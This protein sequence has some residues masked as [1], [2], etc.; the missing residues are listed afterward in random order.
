MWNSM[1]IIMAQG[2]FLVGLVVNFSAHPN[3]AFMHVW[4]Y[5]DINQE[6]IYLAP[7]PWEGYDTM[8]IFKQNTVD[9]NSEFFFSYMGCHTKAKEPNHPYLLG[10]R[11]QMESLLFEER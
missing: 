11:E 7:L 2:H 1:H 3:E 9:L 8:L 10:V 5:I 6:C 4:L